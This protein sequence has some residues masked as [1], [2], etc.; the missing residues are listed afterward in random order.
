MRPTIDCPFCRTKTVE[1]RDTREGLVVPA[2]YRC[3]QTY[4]HEFRRKYDY[5]EPIG[6]SGKTSYRDTARQYDEDR[7]MYEATKVMYD[8]KPIKVVDPKIAE[9]EGLLRILKET[10]L[11]QPLD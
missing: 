4:S 1:I 3:N 8:A 9:R 5:D 6:Y 2:C 10:G 7:M 11:D